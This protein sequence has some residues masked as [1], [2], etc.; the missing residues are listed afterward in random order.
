MVPPSVILSD[1]EMPRM[2]G[3]ELVAALRE[4]DTLKS[5]PVIFISSRTEESQQAAVAGVAE[6]LTKPYDENKLVELIGHHAAATE[7]V[8][9]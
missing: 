6:Y 5:N 3:Y 9:I 2:G 4:D 7:L 1:I 8:A